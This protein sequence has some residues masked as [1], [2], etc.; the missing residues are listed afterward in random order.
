MGEVRYNF[1]AGPA[2]LPAPVRD[3]IRD[4]LD[5]FAGSGQSILELPFSAQPFRDLIARAERDL[6]EL[7]DISADYAVLFLQG[8]ASAQF[9]LLPLNLLGGNA[10]ADYIETGY[11]SRKAIAEAT[12]V[13]QA[14]IAASSAATGFDRVP[15]VGRWTVTP[16]AAY[17]HITSNET[18]DGVEYP[19]TPILRRVP[20]V[21]DM[22]SNFLTRPIDVSCYGVI[23]A[24]AQKN[25]GV[26]GLTVL[27]VRRDLL[28]RAHSF[29]PA[30]FDYTRQADAA[31]LLNTPPIFAV[32]VAGLA[33][34]W[35]KNSG[36]VRA[37]EEASLRKS[38][39]LYR[40]IDSS[41]GF[42]RCP[43]LNEF[44]SRVSVCFRLADELLTERF[45]DEAQ[46]QGLLN[47]KGHSKLGG[48]RA[49]LYNAMP[50]EGA[51]AL[52]GFMADFANRWG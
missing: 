40:A 33:F 30:V 6:R 10:C 42:Y 29:V 28:G 35:L 24:S 49:S 32:Y 13:M 31:S 43:V 19:W 50:E 48:V 9:A 51:A 41:E 27:L 4:E 16:G 5:D 39:I 14:H 7:L 17:L 25:I 45:L 44:R 37:M 36:G 52:A 8:G 26:A 15:E 46:D 12:R 38:A 21:A 47:L 1:S 23:Y 11:W 18:A 2:P 3:R 22:S 20:L 34:E